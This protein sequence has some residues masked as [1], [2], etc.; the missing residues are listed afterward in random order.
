MIKMGKK[1]P[2]IKE[3]Q[4][5]IITD[6][7]SRI[8]QKIP[9][10]AKA[11]WRV[12]AW[13]IAGVISIL[14]KYINYRALQMFP[15]TA[16]EQGLYLWGDLYKIPRGEGTLFEGEIRLTS[17]IDIT[18]NSGT[19]FINNKT[20]IVYLL[21]SKVS[22]AGGTATGLI[23]STESGISSNLDVGDTLSVVNPLGIDS[24]VTV[25][26]VMAIAKDQ[27]AVEDWR[28]RILDRI[29]KP[30]QGGALADY[31]E[32]AEE[33][34]AI[35]RAWAIHGRPGIVY[36]YCESSTEVDGIPTAAQLEEAELSIKSPYRIPL[37]AGV[38]VKPI[39]RLAFNHSIKGLNPD[40]QDN[41]TAIEQALSIFYLSREPFIGGLTLPPVKNMIS[42][43]MVITEIVKALSATGASFDS[44]EITLNGS[45]VKYRELVAGELSK[46][47]AINYDA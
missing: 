32:W 35:K 38:E 8:G 46:L 34:T 29:R 27:E 17:E 25:T 6:I 10:L 18:I 4:N 41:R 14:Y 24:V 16:D 21:Q 20:G 47:G 42:L 2:E 19:Q 43:N 5:R 9:L 12:F 33:P 40:N 39:Q 22:I 15:Q 23:I 36:V 13:A 31:E 1:Q 37:T 11:A 30:P 44:V 7:E 28:S 45:T 3:I 26:L